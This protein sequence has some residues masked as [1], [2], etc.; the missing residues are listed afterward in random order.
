MMLELVWEKVLHGSTLKRENRNHVSCVKLQKALVE[1]LG[2][3]LAGDQVNNSPGVFA[4]IEA[5]EK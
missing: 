4:D 1:Y 5:L 2:I 3:G